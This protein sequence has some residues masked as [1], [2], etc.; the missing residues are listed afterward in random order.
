MMRKRW[1]IGGAA[2][3]LLLVGVGVALFSSSRGTAVPRSLPPTATPIPMQLVEEIVPVAT[4][5]RGWINDL[6]WSLNGE[7]LALATAAGIWLYAADDLDAQP[8]RLEGH[9]APVGS[10][11]FTADGRQLVSGG[12]DKTVRL[13]DVD[14]GDPLMVFEGHNGQIESAAVSPDG[15]TIVSGGFDS[16][17]RVWDVDS[18]SEREVL[19]A[20]QNTVTS[21]AYSPDGRY[22]ASG[23][24]FSEKS[25]V[26]WDAETLEQAAV[27]QNM[28][29]VDSLV[30]SS[31][32]A[33]LAAIVAG[34]IVTVW[35][36]EAHEQIAQ[37]TGQM[38]IAFQ[39][40][41]HALAS[42]GSLS[43]WDADEDAAQPLGLDARVLHLTFSPDGTQLAAADELGDLHIWDVA[44]KVEVASLRG[45]HGAGVNTI[46]FT[47]DGSTLVA[48]G[49]DG[50]G[51][52]G[53][54]QLWNVA[55]HREMAVHRVENGVVR[56]LSI[57]PDGLTIATG[58]ESG[59]LELRA[60]VDGS[61]NREVQGH[62]ARILSVAFTP[63]GTAVATGSEDASARL[64]DIAT[65]Q[66]RAALT[67][68]GGPIRH[69]NI[70]DE[71]S[72]M[73]SEGLEDITRL[74][75]FDHL[76]VACTAG[77]A[78]GVTGM[79]FSPNQLYVATAYFNSI[80]KLADLRTGADHAVLEGHT[81]VV[82]GIAFSPDSRVMA[83]ASM[84]RTIRLWDVETGDLL[85]VLEGHLWDVTS[86]AFSPDSTLL[87]SGSADGTI[88]LWQVGESRAAV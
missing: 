22:F 80:V 33:R 10:V 1:M 29:E 23:S 27:L 64:W 20:H 17:V 46:A 13:W 14:S 55:D 5:G 12:W 63:D 62:Q 87:A 15:Q 54:V 70:T 6:A 3:L 78:D 7:T 52:P 49:G 43:L 61:L 60:G 66:Q 19:Q 28:G 35:D 32:S 57:S 45:W 36:T 39:P 75:G 4:L 40:G 2:G 9:S 79:Q 50:F 41:T 68:L 44:E 82:W 86:L 77:A 37:G 69:L 30:F 88:R 65:G 74:A 58:T 71:G 59:M 81:G 76:N 83:T 8:R 21:V 38:E 73:P 18:G 53:S 11:V 42:G 85:A 26:L 51:H 47:P 25:V 67:D 48:G 31:D 84:D 56:S 16:S 72:L 24:R 34:E